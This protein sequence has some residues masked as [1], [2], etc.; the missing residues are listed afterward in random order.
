MEFVALVFVIAVMMFFLVHVSFNLSE[1][2]DVLK[3]LLILSAMILGAILANIGK[4]IAVE[5]GAG[6][7]IQTALDSAYYVWIVLITILVIYFVIY[8]IVRAWNAVKQKQNQE[9]DLSDEENS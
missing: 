1:N 5:G 6:T 8:F 4:F 3:L 7:E 9:I 2:Y